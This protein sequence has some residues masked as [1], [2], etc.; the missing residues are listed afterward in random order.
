MY[1]LSPDSVGSAA[2]RRLFYVLI[3]LFSII[4]DAAARFV[5]A[6]SLTRSPLA[7]ASVFDS[8]GKFIGTGN[9]A[10]V[11]SCASETD[12]PLTIRY[13]GFHE[14]LVPEVTA[15][16]V[17]LR[18][19]I[20]ELPEVVVEA[21]QKKMLHI[22]AYV[23]EYSTL[24]TY[25]DT[26]AMFREKM[27]D[28]MLPS[29]PGTS[30][31]GWRLPRVLNSKSYYHFTNADGLDSVSDRCNHHFSWTDWIGIP[32]VAA[33]P[34]SL[35]GIVSG[36]DTIHGKYSAAEIWYRNGDRMSID[37][38][39]IADTISRRWAPNAS[40]FFK[41]D[42]VSFERFGLRFNYGDVVSDRIGALDLTGYS[43]NIE[44]RGRGH[45]MFQF[46]RYDRPFFVTTY[47][48]VYILDKE[49]IS[50][51]E[52]KKWQ[53]RK[54][55]SDAIAIYE[56]ME[57]PELQPSVLALIDRVKGIDSDHVRLSLAPDYRLKSR[58]VVKRN[59]HIGRRA[60]FVLKQVTGIT[61]FKS[62]KNFNRRWKQ[63]TREQINRNIQ[64]KDSIRTED[65]MQE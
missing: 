31:K 50:V 38:D 52:A 26:V 6:D 16:T 21:K 18:E 11:V 24:A 41:N 13:M 45:G 30:V 65:K 10:G 27:V 57:A 28:F 48:E 43:F 23:R 25:T 17:F 59:F 54:F 2:G 40:S 44:S 46:H 64:H 58:N 61:Y 36:M 55:D 53:N 5:V 19:N 29:A 8:K 49:Y 33:I 9:I 32:P 39:V 20:S 51:K 15:D 7:N 3:I 1:P 60:L 37:V 4:P 42:N 22:L 12:Y 63:F 62:H 35:V 56:P 47:T 34:Q 14:R